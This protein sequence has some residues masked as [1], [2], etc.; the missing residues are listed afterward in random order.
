M[1]KRISRNL[2]F[3]ICG[4]LAIGL[5][6]TGTMCYQSE[7]R[8][9]IRIGI[10]TGS[11]WN[12]PDVYTYEFIEDA[13]GKFEEA[14]P[15]IKVEYISGIMREDYS[16]WLAGKVVEGTAPDVFMILPEDFSV[17]QKSGSL[18]ELDSLIAGD[19]E[20]NPDD[21]YDGAY[22]YGSIG[23]SQYALPLE[24]APDMMFVNKT[25]LKQYGIDTPDV[26]WTWDDF[27]NIC[28][29]V[30]CD[31]DENGVIDQFGVYNYSLEQAFMTNDVK[32]FD[33]EGRN[34]NLQGENAEQA[35][36]FLQ[37]INSLS[38]GAVVTAGD[39]N[40]GKVAFMPLTLAEYRTYK[41]Y[42]WSIKRYSSFDWDC[43][44]LPKG[45]QGDNISKMNTLLLGINSR[46]KKKQLAWELMKTF[47]Y[48]EEIQSEIYKYRAGGSPLKNILGD[49]QILLNENQE[50][51]KDSSI[52]VSI[53][54]TIME[55]S[56][57]DYNFNN[58][59]QSKEMLRQ[60]I[61]DILKDEKN[62]EIALKQLQREIN[63]YLSR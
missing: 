53:I 26:D 41:P 20:F 31:T 27:Y 52:N 37:R 35:V 2:I 51:P 15:G 59:N 18:L 16:E 7:N 5:I 19:D 17:L 4:L 58:I 22:N 1:K 40:L 45:P 57:E 36:E 62:P 21:F 12:V 6:I 38:G 49:E 11:P 33:E 30:T 34:C 63:Q 10:F 55:S 54:N 44:T 46:S 23:G 42:P 48:D 3:L 47:C 25:L 9:T 8:T 56:S 24:C 13:I 29:K 39:F 14:H 50:L 32:P 43:I 60:G 28:K 61:E